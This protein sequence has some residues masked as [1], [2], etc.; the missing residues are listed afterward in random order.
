MESS[1]RRSIAADAAA[2][3]A[4]AAFAERAER[5]RQP[6]AVFPE[7]VR[8]R[9]LAVLEDE[10]RD[11]GAAQAHRV[12]G[13][14]HPEAREPAL[15]QERARWR[16]RAP[17]GP[18]RAITVITLARSPLVMKCFTPLRTKRSPRRSARVC[19]PATSEPVFGS[20]IA[21]AAIASPD[22]SAGR[23]FSLRKLDPVRTMPM[24][25]IPVWAPTMLQIEPRPLRPS[26]WW[27]MH[28][29]RRA[30][31]GAAVLLGDRDAEEPEPA[32]L[33]PDRVRHRVVALDRLLHRDDRLV[34]ELPHG[35]AELLDVGG[36]IEIH[37]IPPVRRPA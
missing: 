15:D 3:D 5:A 7:P 10:L 23:Y 25:P 24:V 33:A 9:H 4:D 35:A 22:A 29:A 13:A 26:S 34:H 6:L 1:S 21:Y 17:A 36:Q 28:R 37:A 11:V 2:R 18:V 8:L 32:G 12:L 27:T 20:V 16:F 31:P 30:E 19:T 14:R